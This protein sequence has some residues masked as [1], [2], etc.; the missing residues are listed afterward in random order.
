MDS[1]LIVTAKLDNCLVYEIGMDTSNALPMNERETDILFDAFDKIFNST[2]FKFKI[3]IFGVDGQP[4]PK[5]ASLRTQ[6]AA[7]TAERDRMRE[8]LQ[9]AYDFIEPIAWAR[10]HDKV[11]AEALLYD[12]EVVSN[13]DLAGVK[14]LDEL[15]KEPTDD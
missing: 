13:P 10:P 11:A 3:D 7:M 2:M 1:Y 5:L 4:L 15:R 9:R 8:V 14:T 12:M 6:L